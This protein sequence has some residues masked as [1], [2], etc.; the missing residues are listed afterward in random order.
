MMNFGENMYDS[1]WSLY[2]DI[3]RFLKCLLLNAVCLGNIEKPQENNTE[4]DMRKK[5]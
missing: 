4:N 2:Y 1:E 5:S 3:G